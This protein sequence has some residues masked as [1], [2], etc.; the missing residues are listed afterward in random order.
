MSLELKRKG[1]E[2]WGMGLLWNRELSRDDVHTP[3]KLVAVL[4]LS[5]HA[6][7]TCSD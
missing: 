4:Q 2:H 5:T 7:N 6:P 1:A 3:G